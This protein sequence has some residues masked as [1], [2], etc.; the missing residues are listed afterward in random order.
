[1]LFIHVTE[2]SRDKV[3]WN[4][5]YSVVS[6]RVAGNGVVELA[7]CLVLSENA[8]LLPEAGNALDLACG[9]GA[10]ALFLQQRGL[11]TS[12]WDIS[13]VAISELQKHADQSGCALQAEVRD[14]VQSPPAKQSFE[15]IV[16]SRFLD[17]KII[18]ALIDALK[19]GGLIFYQT[20]VLDKQASIGPSNP[21]YLLKTN[22]LLQLFSS[23]TVRVYREEGLEGDLEKGLRNEAMLVAQKMR[24][25]KT[26]S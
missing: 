20:F 19:P 22:E 10:N 16:V 2:E 13:D 5:R 14:V 18:P 8:H 6:S 23:L 25:Q 24:S 12:A 17:R 4:N 21:D 7:P 9:L 3:K 11:E 26:R 15:V 1:M